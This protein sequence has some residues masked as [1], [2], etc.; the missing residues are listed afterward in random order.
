MKKELAEIEKI[1]IEYPVAM[2]KEQFYQI[3]HISKKTAQYLLSTGIVPCRDSGK[4]T[5]KYTIFTDDVIDYLKGDI[6]L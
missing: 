3:A 2:N 6:R 5:R 1:R 4:K